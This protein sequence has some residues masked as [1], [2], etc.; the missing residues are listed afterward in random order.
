MVIRSIVAFRQYGKHLA[1]HCFL[2]LFQLLARLRRNGIAEITAGADHSAALPR[3]RVI[4]TTQRELSEKCGVYTDVF[5]QSIVLDHNAN[6]PW[7]FLASLTGELVVVSLLVLIPLAYSDHLPVFHWNDVILRPAP[8]PAPLPITPSRHEPDTNTSTPAAQPR[9][10]HYDRT[11]IPHPTPAVSFS[12]TPE[13][14]PSI[15]VQGARDGVPGGSQ[16]GGLTIPVP[17]PP[18]PGQA[19][20][21]SAPSAPIRV[22]GT[23][24]MAKLIRMVRPEYPLLAKTARISGVVHLIGIIAKDGT[25]RNLQLVDGHPWLARA[26]MQAVAQWVYKPTLLNGEPVEVIAPI[27]ISFTLGN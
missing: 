4:L 16:L 18:P 23:V 1:D 26:A 7:N 20:H 12:F 22:G 11:A 5:E 24:Q 21:A 6:R 2:L 14:P 19:V 13:A 25:I 15:G 10:F 3:T 9:I 8:P 27:E 17:P